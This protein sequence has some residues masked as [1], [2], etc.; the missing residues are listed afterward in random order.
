MGIISKGLGLAGRGGGER[1]GEMFLE[2]MDLCLKR[3]KD[4]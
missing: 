4:T 2:S 3:I 1:G